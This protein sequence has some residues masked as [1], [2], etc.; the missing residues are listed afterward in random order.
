ML[1]SVFAAFVGC[2]H[3]GPPTI[4]DDRLAY[5]HAIVSSWKQQTLLNIV[6]L[7]YAD[8]PEFVD[9]PSI[10][11]GYEKGRT[12]SFGLGSEMYP[13]NAASMFWNPELR[14]ER[15]MVDRPTISYSPQTDSEFTRNLTNPIPPTSILNLI[16]SGYPADVVM[17]LAVESINGVRNRGF[18]GG[19]EKGDPEFRQALQIMRKAQASGHVSMRV[20]PGADKNSPEVVL[21]IRSENLAPALAAEIG[22]FR[23]L[24]RLDPETREFKI[25]FGMLPQTKNE[26]AFRTRSIFGIMTFLAIDVQV[27]PNHL[28]D[29]RAPDLGDTSPTS[30]PQL[31]VLSGCEKPCDAY[32]A[33]CYQ[34]H[35]FWID[36]RDFRSKRTILYLKVLLALADTRQK[37]AGP[38]LTIRAN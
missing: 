28:A 31:S 36:Q 7:R 22:E 14:H 33:V 20:V 27:P 5:N 25:V 35:W 23:K 21:G 37:E 10:V 29:G 8:V 3:I 9:V 19:Y 38:A 4:P 34:G 2:R 1:C 18:A 30:P 24:L 26:I 15:S 13:H 17:E 12:S 32:T 11:N 6:R 16:E